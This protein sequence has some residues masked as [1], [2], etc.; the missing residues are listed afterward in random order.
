MTIIDEHDEPVWVALVHRLRSLA[1]QHGADSETG[2]LVSLAADQ[3]VADNQQ[4]ERLLAR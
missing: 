4:I 3:I 2:W 1:E